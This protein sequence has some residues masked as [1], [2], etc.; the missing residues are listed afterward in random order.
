MQIY[1]VMVTYTSHTNLRVGLLSGASAFHEEQ[2]NIRK[3]SMCRLKKKVLFI[4]FI[5]YKIFFIIFI[6][7]MIEENI[8][9]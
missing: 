3:E 6:F 5:K 7:Q 4:L 2:R 9:L 1:K 8:S